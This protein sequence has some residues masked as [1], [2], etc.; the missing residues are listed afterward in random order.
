MFEAMHAAAEGVPLETIDQS[1]RDYGMPVG[2][3]ELSDRVGLDVC[4]HV[5]QIVAAALGRQLPD[6]V[7][8]QVLIDAGKLGKKTGEGLYRWQGD[9][10]QRAKP[11]ALP[12]ADLQDRLMLILANECVACLREGLVESADAIDAGLIFGSGYA[13]FRG[14]PLQAA[15]DRGVDACV[16]RLQ[17]L[18]AR[19]GERFTPDDGWSLLR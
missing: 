7:P 19:Y 17:E 18:A 1:A 2:P 6:L 16:A 13:P 8:L 12:P 11:R 5:G 14:G 3:V 9:R 4:L 10:P 15:R